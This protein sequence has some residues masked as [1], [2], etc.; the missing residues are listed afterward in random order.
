[1]VDL[2]QMVMWATRQLVV[3][4]RQQ[5][6]LQV[7]AAVEILEVHWESMVGLV[8]VAAA[9]VVAAVVPTDWELPQKN[10]AS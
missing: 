2:V 3:L 8:A 4:T 5:I 1:M 6:V 9:A 10:I 7:A